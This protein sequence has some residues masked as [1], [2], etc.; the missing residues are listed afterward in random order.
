MG[1]QVLTD[2]KQFA[3]RNSVQLL[4]VA[5]DSKHLGYMLAI[6]VSQLHV[7]SIRF[8]KSESFLLKNRGKCMGMRLKTA[9]L[10][11]VP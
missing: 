10:I 3:S 5:I 8:K 6:I 1:N 2:Y 7:S 9:N 11:I 4:R